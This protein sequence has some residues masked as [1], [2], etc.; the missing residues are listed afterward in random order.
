[1][2][3]TSLISERHTDRHVAMLNKLATLA[4]PLAESSTVDEAKS[5]ADAAKAIEL[6]ARRRKAGKP[7]LIQAMEY[8]RRAQR[9]MGRMIE[10]EYGT[11]GGDRR[12]S[13]IVPLESLGVS[14]DD[15][16]FCRAIAKASDEQFETWLDDCRENENEPTQSVAVRLHLGAHVGNN[17]GNSEWYTPGE[18]VDAVR[19]AMG[20]I[21]TDPCS[22]TAANGVVKAE[23]FYDESDNGLGREWHGR[24]FVNPPYGDGTVDSFAS[25]LLSEISAGR[26]AQAVFLVNNCTETKW[27]QSLI[28]RA[29]AVCFPRGRISF[30]SL[31]QKSKSPLQGQ[32]IIYF[33][34]NAKRFKS[35]FSGIGFTSLVR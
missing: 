26:T 27:F 4:A 13:G 24:V 9:I 14:K 7:V 35:V 15:S 22:C 11:Q 20:G 28:S 3:K 34:T 16:R 23:T 10:K 33:G 12:S 31:E 21:D 1:M 17:S 2:K 25:K 8:Q 32:A 19:Q 18:Y 6:W 5:V 29:S 30:W